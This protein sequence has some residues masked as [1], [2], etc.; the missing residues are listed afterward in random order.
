LSYPNNI[1]AKVTKPARYTGGEWNSILKS[2]D[3]TPI[4]VALS[5]PDIYEIAMPNMALPILYKMLNNYPDVLAERV[6]APWTDMEEAL[7]SNGIP[8]LSLESQRPLNSFDLVG[9]S[10][11]Y[12]LTYTNILNILDLGGVPV[13]AAER[14]KDDPLVI[15]GGSGAFNPEPLADFIDAFVLGDGEAVLPEL[16]D[17]YR[18]FKSN[19]GSRAKLLS[20]LSKLRGVYVPSLYGV[21]YG[22]DGLVGKVIPLGGNGALV[23]RVM[24]E[25]LPPP[26]TAPI[27]PYIETVQDRGAVEISRGCSRGCRFCHAGMICRPVRRRSPQG[28]IEA[29]GSIR[30]NCGYDEFSLLSL[31]TSDYPD[32]EGLIGKID[33]RFSEER[34]AVTLPS[35]RI[36]PSS[37]KL[38]AALRGKRRGGLTF[39]PETASPR[40]Q[41]VI[42]KA[43]AEEELMA[44]AEAAFRGGWTTL[45]LYYMLGL[46]TEQMADIEEIARQIS[47]V[48]ALGRLA[49]GRRPQLRIN[50]ATFVP[51]AHTPF[52]WVGQESEQSL[53]EKHDFLRNSLKQRGIHLSWENTDISRLEA[54]LSRGDRRIGQVIYR[55]WQLGATF[56]AWREHFNYDKWLKAFHETGIDPVFYANRERSLE[57]TLPWAHLSGGA[58]SVF[59]KR[60]YQHA[61]KDETT[62]DCRTASC[63]VC[64]LE[65]QHPDCATKLSG[66]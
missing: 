12:E 39:A 29:I 26:V 3:E 66:S 44:T 41:K 37:V 23:E 15:G 46:P 21:E 47:D 19:G 56:D 65:K 59:L 48:Y 53:K 2:W 42:N 5:Y 58:D 30:A 28:I 33:E 57:E 52:Q 32:I 20:E 50:L 36:S 6:F 45:K 35:L 55:A 4:K 14:G 11:G 7:R 54:V 31:N 63:N 43:V 49:S 22:A 13:L 16:I 18:R 9:F 10:L 1:L 61:L 38:V 24:V 17:C 64:G 25:Q 27:V 8:L 40:L 34:L 51:K 62:D 60:E